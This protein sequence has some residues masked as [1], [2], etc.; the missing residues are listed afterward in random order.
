MHH[1][2][3]PRQHQ[4]TYQ[5][6]SRQDDI[7]DNW[8]SQGAQQQM[9]NNGHARSDPERDQEDL[10]NFFANDSGHKQQQNTKKNTTVTRV[11]DD[12][13]FMGF[14]V[15]ERQPP[16][17]ESVNKEED[18]FWD[19]FDK[20]VTMAD[21]SKSSNGTKASNTKPQEDLWDFSSTETTPKE[22]RKETSASVQNGTQT[23]KAA[24][25]Q[26]GW[27]ENWDDWGDWEK[28]K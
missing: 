6:N 1:N 17:T 14:D 2:E 26:Q 11:V 3:D 28:K 22:Q 16:K 24:V 4:R 18:S 15:E 9:S 27:E 12:S 23:G 20:K 19:E 10:E 8:S 7:W 5:S 21:N 13:N 25:K